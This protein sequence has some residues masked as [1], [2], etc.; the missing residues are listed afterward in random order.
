MEVVVGHDEY[1]WGRGYLKKLGAGCGM[2]CCCSREGLGTYERLKYL[3]MLAGSNVHMSV[4]QWSQ[5][6]L[7]VHSTS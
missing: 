1:E 7:L 3:S 5:G 6:I 4:P 2:V